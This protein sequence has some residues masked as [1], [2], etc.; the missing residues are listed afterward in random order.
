M[1]L[2][3]RSTN[4]GAATLGLEH[5]V[6]LQV[7]DLA[8]ENSS[9]ALGAV[10]VGVDPREA[11]GAEGRLQPITIQIAGLAQE[12]LV[13][14]MR[15]ACSLVIATITHPTATVRQASAPSGQIASPMPVARG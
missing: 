14:R 9:S 5:R 4:A 2:I 13:T 11:M 6:V 10:R 3:A 7:D 8:A 1:A 15:T 12:L